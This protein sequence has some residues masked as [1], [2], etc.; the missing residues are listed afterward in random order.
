[1]S[2]MIGVAMLAAWQ[3]K[4]WCWGE[5]NYHLGQW[6]SGGGCGRGKLPGEGLRGGWVDRVGLVCWVGEVGWMRVK[7]AVL[8]RE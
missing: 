4:A 6:E 2:A 7:V 3:W 8:R 1:M 5:G